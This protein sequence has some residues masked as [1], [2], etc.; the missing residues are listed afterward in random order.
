MNLQVTA[1]APAAINELSRSRRIGILLIC[2][3]SLLIVGL[4]VT[5][6]NIALPSIGKDLH[7][8]VSGLQWT[9]DAYTLVLASLLMLSGSMA[10]RLGRR[11]TFMVGLVTFV[12]G[13]LLCSLA[14]NLT[15][16]VVFRMVQAIG[17]SM[18][19]PVAMSI[20][21]NTF[22]DPKERAQAIGVWG[23]VIGFS[24]ALGPV[25][26]GLLVG[27]VGWRSIFWINIPIGLVAAVLAFRYIPE[28]RAPKPRRIDGVGQVLVITLLSS[29]TYGII[30]APSRGWTSGVILAAFA[31]TI[32]SLVGLLLWEPR[33]AEPLIDLRFFRSIPFSAATVIAVAAFASLGGFLFL[34]TL[35][36]QEV[37][38]LSPLQA[39]IDTLP[40]AAMA[41]V[42]PTISGR[43][44]GTRGARIPLVIAGVTLLV[45]C[46]M[47]VT[48]SDSTPFSWLFAA[49]V[50]FG[51][52]FGFVNAPITNA[53]V[54]GMPRAQ[55]GVASAIASTSRQIGATLGV[56]VVGALVTSKIGAVA[57][58]VN[59][60]FAEASRAGWWVLAGCGAVVLVLGLVATSQ[61]A[62]ES[63]RRTAQEINPEFLEGQV[64]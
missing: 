40:M 17:G 64:R 45:S 25:I 62:L 26:G 3:M 24:M 23:A 18:L 53:A 38:G 7:A 47:L 35:Y 1:A 15:T 34:N 32:A 61:R 58:G 22:T 59:I 33:R 50:A 10:D 54:S 41:L 63:A 9:I 51:I 13:S 46:L 11:K 48:I 14:P 39:G 30:E 42:F 55:A 21:T 2:S 6:V 8:S 5:I 29:L 12:G 36:L 52:G 4:D 56:A 19:N 37:R 49:Y 27:S 60:D 57:G 16:L 28:S 31:V 20:I 43:I 44:V